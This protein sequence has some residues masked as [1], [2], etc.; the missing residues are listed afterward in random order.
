MKYHGRQAAQGR[1]GDAVEVQAVPVAT[2]AKVASL[3]KST[4]RRSQSAAER[5]HFSSFNEALNQLISLAHT[6]TPEQFLQALIERSMALLDADILLIGNYHVATKKIQVMGQS[7]V[8]ENRWQLLESV[9]LGIIE[10]EWQS[11]LKPIVCAET[12]SPRQMPIDFGLGCYAVLPLTQ[13]ARSWRFLFLGSRRRQSLAA[14]PVAYLMTL[15]Q[16]IGLLLEN[17]D[18]V[19][20]QRKAI[21]ASQKSDSE[22]A[23]LYN[24]L[25]VLAPLGSAD[26]LQQVADKLVRHLVLATDCDAVLMR[27]FDRQKNALGILAQRGFASADVARLFAGEPDVSSRQVCQEGQ[28]IYAK[29]LDHDPRAEMS[30]QA[31]TGLKSC[32]LLPLRGKDEVR[33]VIYL[34]SRRLDFFPEEKRKYLAALANFCGIVLENS[35]L[36]QASVRYA[37]ELKVSNSELERFAYVA[38]HDL[39]EPL[40]MVTAYTQLLAKRYSHQLDNEASEY[41]A[42]AVEGAKRMQALINDLLTF[43]RLDA[44]QMPL[45]AADCEQILAGATQSLRNAIEASGVQLTRD[46]LPRVM[47]DPGQLEQLFLNLISNAITYRSAESPKIHVGCLRQGARWLFS[48]TD[49]GIGIEPEYAEKIFIIFQRLHTW[50]QYQGTGIGLAICKKIIERHGE[51]I[52][53]ESQPGQGSTFFF[54]LTDAEGKHV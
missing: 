51:K 14:Q 35:E 21:A 27:N 39:Q 9:V 37:D 26:S 54:T 19:A 8:L 42:I 40:R 31:A 17:A 53:V 41:I 5:N 15:A 3:R 18:L 50:D 24:A 25:K 45:V 23:A 13:T 33:G 10:G 1:D 7:G 6:S 2:A 20:Q 46:R 29:D 11:E 43:S 16:V 44:H 34:G 30:R 28:E 48:V 32:A 36:L 22:L 49:N 47:A 4:S 12:G 38:S 52:W